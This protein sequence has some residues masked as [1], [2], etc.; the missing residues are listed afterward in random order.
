MQ[1][2]LSAAFGRR[3]EMR[4]IAKA[5]KA[6]KIKTTSH[7]INQRAK[8]LVPKT[9]KHRLKHALT[10]W[11]DIKRCHI[12]IRFTDFTINEI[13]AMKNPSLINP[14]LLT[15]ARHTET[16]IAL[17]F[18]IPVVVVGGEQNVFDWL[19]QVKHLKNIKALYRYLRGK[20]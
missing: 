16:G 18:G 12:F 14:S 8:G 20:L 19:P 10:D 17:A 5:L 1:V 15:G 3:K 9:D 6:Q 4:A 13:Y 7:W 11:N 2:Y